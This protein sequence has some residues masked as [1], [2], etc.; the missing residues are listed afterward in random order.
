MRIGLIRHFK[1]DCPHKKMMTA[2]NSVNGLENMRRQRLLKEGRN[3]WNRVGYML[4]K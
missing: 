4:C 3:V 1:V 2:E